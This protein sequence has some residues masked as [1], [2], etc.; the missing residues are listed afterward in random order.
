MRRLLA[1]AICATACLPAYA[2]AASCEPRGATIERYVPFVNR[3][4]ETIAV[5]L[6]KPVADDGCRFPVVL[7]SSPYRDWTSPQPTKVNEDAARTWWVDRGYVFAF[8]DVP[9]AG[10]SD[11]EW[12]LFCEHEQLSG[13]DIVEALGSE[14][15]SN[16]KV[17][18]IG[19][20]Y[21]AI[22]AL[23][24]AQHK[25]PHLAAIIAANFYVDLYSDFFYPGGM[26]RF[27]DAEVLHVAFNG[28]KR[29]TGRYDTAD[30]ARTAALAVAH[31]SSAP[32]QWPTSDVRDAWYEERSIHPER[33]DVPVYLMGG[34]NDMFD[35]ATWGFYDRVPSTEKFLMQ[36][37]FTH[38][39]FFMPPGAWPCP[40]MGTDFCGLAFFER[41]IKGDTSAELPARVRAYV[42]PR[43]PYLEGDAKPT[44]T[45][46]SFALGT[47]TATLS[48]DPAAGA[49]GGQWFLRG[50]VPG[51][52]PPFDFYLG[53]DGPADQR[54]A[55]QTGLS[56]ASPVLEHDVTVL[57][58]G[59]LSIVA[60]SDAST[61]DV[62]VHVV[63]EYPVGD[64]AFPV[65]YAYLVT[66]GWRHA[67]FT[68]GERTSV[69]VEI[70]PT[71]YVFKAGHRIRIDLQPSDVPRFYPPA[72]PANLTV[73][74]DASSVSL[75]ALP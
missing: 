6:Y 8:A 14:P 62:V 15:W 18:M 19:G 75:P 23:L 29:W 64:A 21:P 34:W 50:S 35:R 25:P 74:L 36:G 51:A 46:F 69:D 72:M 30:P 40:S 56:L 39:P 3:F 73:D 33:I 47:G 28:L 43:G 58:G 31:A 27:V 65:G 5:D 2:R 22:N 45:P 20:S 41:F 59:T 44:T 11:G 48:Y 16:G 42:Q 60:S 71:G 12:C 55:E 37:P 53:V 49:T 68:P 7:Q 70:W 61:A 24:I 1:L 54:V 32:L 66:S 57:G 17:G 63:D 26:K 13:Y 4:G 38:V 9:G 10:G 52:Y 67:S